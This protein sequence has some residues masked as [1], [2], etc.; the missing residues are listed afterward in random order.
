[1]RL[2]WLVLIC[3]LIFML[4]MDYLVDMLATYVQ[5]LNEHISQAVCNDHKYRYVKNLPGR[6]LPQAKSPF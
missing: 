5:L 2:T 1:M 4:N 6:S 3:L